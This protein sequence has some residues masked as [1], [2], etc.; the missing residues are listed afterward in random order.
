MNALG[1]VDDPRVDPYIEQLSKTDPSLDIRVRAVELLRGLRGAERRPAKATVTSAHLTRPM[2]KLF[3]YAREAR[4][5]DLHVT[6][7]E[8]PV[9][10]INGIIQRVE[11]KP[12][13][14]GQVDALIDE[15]LDPVRRPI[16]AE[17]GAVDFCY[18]IPGI[19]RYRVNVFRQLRGTSAVVRV[20][21]NVTPTLDGPRAPEGTST[22]SACTTRGSS[23]SPGRPGRASRT[24]SRRS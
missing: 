9:L 6:P 1:K 8:P 16:L 20:I 3:A 19:G 24:R 5:S 23:C 10:R 18:S 21:P 11:M 2:E 17:K 7:D 22:R 15:I 14:A 12:L 4:A 13:S